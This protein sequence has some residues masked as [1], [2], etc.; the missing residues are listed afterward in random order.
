M[1]SALDPFLSEESWSSGRH[2]DDDHFFRCLQ[3]IVEHPEFDADA[4]DRYMTERLKLDVVQSDRA[5]EILKEVRRWKDHYVTAARVIHR[6]LR[7]RVVMRRYWSAVGG[8][9]IKVP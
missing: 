5:P 7:E 8:Q 2:F 9:E 6:H 1:Y 4:M 3:T